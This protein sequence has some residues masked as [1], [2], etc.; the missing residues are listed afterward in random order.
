MIGNDPMTG[1]SS[2]F[3]RNAG[4]L[5]RGRD[6]RPKQIDVV[7]VVNT[8]HD[9]GDPLETH[10]GIDGGFGKVHA[11]ANAAFLVLHEYQVPDLDESIAIGVRRTRRTTLDMIAMIVK[12]LRTRSAGAG[13]AHAPEVVRG[14]DTHDPAVR[15]SGDLFPQAV[16]LVVLGEHRHHQPFGVETVFLGDEVPSEFNGSIL[17]IVAK[18]EVAEHF[19]K[20]VMPSRVAYIIEIVVLT[21]GPNAFL[22]SGRSH[23]VALFSAHEYILE[24]HH[25]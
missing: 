2:P 20:R 22:R 6:Q 15:Q 17:E 21:A 24:L 14:R 8:L 5:H 19:K 23:V 3:R 10:A 9:G 1:P 11:V 25:P 18:G 16:R 4:G 12:D 13:I 7:V